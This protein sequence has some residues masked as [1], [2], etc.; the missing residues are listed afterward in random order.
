MILF[1]YREGREW[2]NNCQ[3]GNG[4]VNLSERTKYFKLT[5]YIGN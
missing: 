3:N 5:E 2:T 4:Q 1:L